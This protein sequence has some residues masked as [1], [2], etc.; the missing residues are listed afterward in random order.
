MPQCRRASIFPA[1]KRRDDVL[2]LSFTTTS[3]PF[4]NVCSLLRH[5]SRLRHQRT[6]RPRWP[7]R[8]PQSL[9]GSL[10]RRRRRLRR[11]ARVRRLPRRQ[12]VPRRLCRSRGL[13]GPC[14]HDG[15]EVG[16]RREVHA[17]GPC[18]GSRVGDACAVRDQVVV[19]SFKGRCWDWDI[20]PCGEG[21]GGVVRLGRPQRS[22][23]RD[24]TLLARTRREACSRFVF[25]S[26]G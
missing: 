8:I 12:I 6:R 15:E 25:R 26:L 9:L 20:L 10:P 18:Y 23:D 16:E 13:V 24:A 2:P 11:C 3:D 22:R 17:G 14:R 21:V 7:H 5:N 1:K 4:S 19:K